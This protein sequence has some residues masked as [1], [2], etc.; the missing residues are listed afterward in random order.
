ML[1][2][3]KETELLEY[4]VTNSTSFA[5]LQLSEALGCL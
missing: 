5:A 2:K 4:L 3:I 1:Q